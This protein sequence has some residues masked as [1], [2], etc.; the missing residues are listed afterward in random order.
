MQLKGL[1]RFFAIAL[2]LICLY[3]LSFTWFVRSHEKAMDEK[4]QAWMKRFPTPEQQYPGDK[5]KQAIY[6]DS[7]AEVKK[8]RVL[9]LLDS[10]KETKL[11]FGLVT[12][13]SAKESELMLGLD[14]QGGM[15]VTM[16]VGLDGLIKS[17]ANYTKDANFNKALENAVAR[18]ANSGAN[19]ITLFEEEFKK[20]N[21]TGKLAPYFAARSNG[22]VKIDASDNVVN[23]YLT[24]Q[25][26]AAF[27]NTYRIL[28]TRID[29]F[30]VASPSINPDPAKGI[31]NIEL[32]GVNDK[33][34][35]RS[36]LQSTANLQFLKFI[37]L[38]AP[39]YK[40][41]LLLPTKQYKIC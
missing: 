40:M 1:V 11:A 2:I 4:A 24:A 5:E 26:T 12:Y 7:L 17:L 19:L 6:A 36:Y 38:K 20:V 15:S 33:E 37:L 16:E 39:T 10:T 13:R 28:R 21:P 9:R 3:Q 8:E 31:I 32:A 27:N 25:A 35:V 23:E 41:V 34:R 14:L 29:R 22:K 30:G 18:K